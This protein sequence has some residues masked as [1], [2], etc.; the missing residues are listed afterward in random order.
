MAARTPFVGSGPRVDRHPRWWMAA[1]LAGG[2]ALAVQGR[3]T[4]ALAGATGQPLQAALWN[5][6]TGWLMLSAS[7]L[8]PAPRHALAE[9]YR[10]YRRAHLAWWAFFGGVFGATFV[11]SQGLS[12]PIVGVAMFTI[13]SVAGQT[14]GALL[15]DRAGVGPAGVVP[16]SGPRAAAGVAAL[17]GVAIAVSGRIGGSAFT[18]V[19]LVGGMAVSVSAAINGRVAVA[20]RN[21]LTTGWINFTWG[22]VVLTGLALVR[23]LLG[24]E[25]APLLVPGMPWWGYV[26]G[27]TGTAYVVASAL[28]VRH[29]GVLVTMLCVLTG[30]L[31]G[32]IALDLAAASTRHLVTPWL[33]AGTAI[34]FVAAYAGNRASLG[35]RGR[36]AA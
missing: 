8:L 17:A 32:S 24:N 2:L 15:V 22:V 14:V 10:A 31:S 12:V 27:V 18:V 6:A 33:L 9:S 1:A 26:G 4:G 7:F 28:A 30:Q 16:W 35:A 13:G 21:V 20:S 23:L 19:P 25:P 29:L 11:A 5:F 3:S 34:T 36:T